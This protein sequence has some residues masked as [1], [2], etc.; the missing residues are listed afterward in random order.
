PQPR[1]AGVRPHRRARDRGTRARRVQAGRGQLPL[2]GSWRPFATIADAARSAAERM[3]A[4]IVVLE[5][6][7]ARARSL[8]SDVEMRRTKL[9][10]AA[11]RVA[12]A[13]ALNS[14]IWSRRAPPRTPRRYSPI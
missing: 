14:R 6:R 4:V 9:P 11:A 1:C 8:R 10:R 7:A 12:F 2:G 5:T 3:M 13:M